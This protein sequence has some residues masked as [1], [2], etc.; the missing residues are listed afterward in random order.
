MSRC[1]PPTSSFKH[2]PTP[3]A[4]G[5]TSPAASAR[6]PEN[7]YTAASGSS[8][9]AIALDCRSRN[10]FRSA[11][12]GLA[13][14]RRAA[15]RSD[16]KGESPEGLTKCGCIC[17]QRKEK[18]NPSP[19]KRNEPRSTDTSPL[20]H[21]C[22]SVR[23][24]RA[25]EIQV[26]CSRYAWVCASAMQDD[27][28]PVMKRLRRFREQR[29][30]RL[31]PQRVRR[32]KMWRRFLEARSFS[33]QGLPQRARSSGKEEEEPS[34]QRDRSSGKEEE[35]S[36]LITVP[37]VEGVSRDVWA[38]IMKVSGR[39]VSGRMSRASHYLRGI[40]LQLPLIKALQ[41]IPTRTTWWYTTI[42]EYIVHKGYADSWFERRREDSPRMVP[43]FSVP[44]ES[45]TTAGL[46][47]IISTTI[48]LSSRGD[49]DSLH[50]IRRHNFLPYTENS[51]LEY[52]LTSLSIEKSMG[53]NGD[54]TTN[55]KNMNVKQ[56]E[57]LLEAAICA[58]H[59]HTIGAIHAHHPNF[60]GVGDTGNPIHH[61]RYAFSFPQVHTLVYL[62]SLERD[63]MPVFLNTHWKYSLTYIQESTM[64]GVPG[65]Q[66][67]PIIPACRWFITKFEDVKIHYI[68]FALLNS[69]Q[70]VED[71]VH[72]ENRTS[73]TDKTSSDINTFIMRIMDDYD[74]DKG[75][76]KRLLENLKNARTTRWFT[77]FLHLFG[78]SYFRDIDEAIDRV[79]F[80]DNFMRSI[81]PELIAIWDDWKTENDRYE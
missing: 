77:R 51:L 35:T 22:S 57:K 39:V 79:F 36:Q 25:C 11:D 23:T 70:F 17:V 54:M 68:L 14:A 58:G 53:V 75:T 76:I 13:P 26:S 34:R 61:L 8:V 81:M 63:W 10:R 73:S 6:G 37:I 30:R 50:W 71:T 49:A 41:V 52:S 60:I 74:V 29:V 3:R 27:I 59:T 28:D 46:W 16:A 31:E 66:I 47:D 9:R 21:V 38:T 18:M 64:H 12:S 4:P 78:H 2:A 24:T 1:A 69:N 44:M 43:G 62:K 48:L 40:F 55:L 5:H 65:N 7:W 33:A 42:I 56:V 67:Y 20:T 32:S 19:P 15:A 80:S 45:S 72:A